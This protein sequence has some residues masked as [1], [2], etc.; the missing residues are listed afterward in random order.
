MT[1]NHHNC[2][3]SVSSHMPAA[4]G[5]SHELSGPSISAYPAT[6]NSKHISYQTPSSWFWTSTWKPFVRYFNCMWLPISFNS[7]PSVH[8]ITGHESPVVEYRYSSTLSLTS[9]LDGVV[10][11]QLHAPASLPPGNARYPLCKGLGGP[12]GRSGRVRKISPHRYSN[13]GPSSP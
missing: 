9:A 12:Q 7:C 8:P 3:N 5:P 4:N 2:V 6:S 1:S 13:P 11:S 10:G